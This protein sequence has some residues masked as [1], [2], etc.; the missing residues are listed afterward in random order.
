M[1]LIMSVE[2]GFGGQ[3]FMPEVL[4]KIRFTRHLC[5]VL[6]IREGGVIDDTKTLPPFNIEVDGG[7][8]DATAAQCAE[9]GANIFVSGST[10]FKAPDMKQAISSM[11]QSATTHFIEKVSF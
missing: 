6:G 8:T 2:P 1:I 3:A 7:I 10:L 5:N 11:R 9:A 4:E